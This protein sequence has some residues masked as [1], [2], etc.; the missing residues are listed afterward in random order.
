MVKIMGGYTEQ[1]LDFSKKSV[2]RSVLAV[3][4]F[5]SIRRCLLNPIL[6]HSMFK[7]PNSAVTRI[8]KEIDETVGSSLNELSTSEQEKVIATIS[9]LANNTI[10]GAIHSGIFIADSFDKYH[11]KKRKENEKKYR[12]DLL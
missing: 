4:T 6:L 1:F 5:F 12:L 11:E 3:C 7:D 8:A 9:K 10:L 2:Q